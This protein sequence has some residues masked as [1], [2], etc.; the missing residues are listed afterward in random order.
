MANAFSKVD[1][2]INPKLKPYLTIL[3]SEPISEDL[4]KLFCK[5][6]EL[7]DPIIRPVRI[8]VVFARKYFIITIPEDTIAC[9]IHELLIYDLSKLEKI[10]DK[11]YIIAVFLEEFIHC[12]LNSE[13]ENLV[14]RKT[15]ELYPEL[16]FDE[17]TGKYLPRS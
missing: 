15:G 7:L 14:A 5:A 3:T 10:T 6:T 8:K 13:D 4:V 16:T 17:K 1:W 2:P 12:Y 9:R 11:R